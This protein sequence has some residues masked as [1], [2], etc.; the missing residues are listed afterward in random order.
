MGLA[1]LLTVVGIVGWLILHPELRKAQYQIFF[2]RSDEEVTKLDS[3]PLNKAALV[4]VRTVLVTT[5]LSVF[6]IE[7]PS[8]INVDP[9]A[10]FLA[11][12]GFGLVSGV[13]SYCCFSKGVR[14]PATGEENDSG[15]K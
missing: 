5:L 7:G 11:A 4:A 10:G 2:G 8:R 1:L 14:A 12:I 13:A 15:E 3:N 6:L 9:I